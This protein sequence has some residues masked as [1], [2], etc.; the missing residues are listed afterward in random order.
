MQCPSLTCLRPQPVQ[1]KCCPRCPQ[2]LSN[3][4]NFCSCSLRYIKSFVGLCE[5]CVY[6]G[7]LKEPG[8]QWIVRDNEFC[9]ECVCT[10]AGITV[11]VVQLLKHLYVKDSR[12]NPKPDI[13]Y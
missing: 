13:C 2:A 10:Q 8:N 1:G 6:N 9:K 11:S 7:Q 4:K 3:G 5:G 12:E